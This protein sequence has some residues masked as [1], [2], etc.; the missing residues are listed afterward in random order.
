MPF[1][2]PGA[3]TAPPFQPLTEQYDDQ[4]GSNLIYKGWAPLGSATSAAAWTIQKFTYNG[5]NQLI[6][7]QWAVPTTPYVIYV[8][9]DN[10]ASL[11]YK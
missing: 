10:R 1:P 4:G 8:I 11:T 7:T 3:G 6:Q 5:S 2:T 9:W